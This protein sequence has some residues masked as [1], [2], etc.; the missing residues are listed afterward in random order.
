MK[1]FRSKVSEAS[2]TVCRGGKVEDIERR[3]APPRIQ[4]GRESS[5]MEKPTICV[6]NFIGELFFEALRLLWYTIHALRIGQTLKKKKHTIG[7]P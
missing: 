1:Y 6:E 5:E 4:S 3:E 7:D 2:C